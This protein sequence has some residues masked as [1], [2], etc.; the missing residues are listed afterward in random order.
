MEKSVFSVDSYTFSILKFH[1]FPDFSVDFN[2][3]YTFTLK[4]TTYFF[5]V[6]I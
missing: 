6:Y 2:G 5:Y 1:T 3:W 4:L